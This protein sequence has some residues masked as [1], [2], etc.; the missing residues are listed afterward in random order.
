MSERI[1]IALGFDG[2][3]VPHAANMMAAIVRHAP[4]A[5]LRFILLQADVSANEKAR[6]ESAIP[7][8]EFVWIDVGDD[9]LPAYSERGHFNRTVLFRLGLET[10]APADCKRVLYV[11]A[12]AIVVGD[13]RELWA[14]D[15]GPHAIGAA[16]DCYLD[17]DTFA[18][19]WGLSKDGRYFNAGVQVIDLEK[20]R[21]GRF[22]TKAL[23]FVVEHDKKLLYVDQDALNYVFW[24][25]S[26][27]LEPTWN[28]QRYLKPHEIANETAPDKRWGHAWPRLIHY[29]G[30][31]KPWMR[32]VWHPWAW[33]YWENMLRTPYANEV[34]KAFGMGFLQLMRLRLR[35]WV[36][37]PRGK[38]PEPRA[39]RA[40]SVE[41]TKAPL[42]LTEAR[43]A[44]S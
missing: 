5:K 16:T 41:P 18:A 2:R 21:A 15:L 3:Y 36:R 42:G 4:G 44:K 19:T 7:G 1:D 31:E 32:N 43:S 26:A 17:A 10:M 20:V 35:W 13:I 39:T 33:L 8:P 14:F 23:D 25:N 11:D 37:R 27:V 34:R 24:K 28:V 40:A 30:T 9:D 22:F 6:L 12:D 29:I 38:M